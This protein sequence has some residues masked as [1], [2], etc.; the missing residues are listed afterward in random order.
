MVLTEHLS[1]V[2]ITVLSLTC[3]VSTLLLL[4][5]GLKYLQWKIGKSTVNCWFCNTDTVVPYRLR[6]RWVCGACK[7]YNGFNASGDYNDKVPAM[8]DESLNPTK[9]GAC[10]STD[11]SATIE[12]HVKL[13]SRCTRNQLLKV[14]QLAQFEPIIEENFELEAATFKVKLDKLYAL[15]RICH[16][17]TERHIRMQDTMIRGSMLSVQQRLSAKLS[18]LTA[19]RPYLKTTK[20]ALEQ[21]AKSLSDIPLIFLTFGVLVLSVIVSYYSICESLKEVLMLPFASY[22]HSFVGSSDPEKEMLHILLISGWICSMAVLSLQSHKQRSTIFACGVW[23]TYCFSAWISKHEFYEKYIPFLATLPF[24]KPAFVFKLISPFSSA[25]LLIFSSYLSFSSSLPKNKKASGFKHSFSEFQKSQKMKKTPSPKNALNTSMYSDC[26]MPSDDESPQAKRHHTQM[27]E[28]FKRP[29][30]VGLNG[31]L[32]ALNLK[33]DEDFSSSFTHFKHPASVHGGNTLPS[34]LHTPPPS[35]SSSLLSLASHTS[36]PGQQM[37][38]NFS[39][40]SVFAK[41][42]GEVPFQRYKTSTTVTGWTHRQQKPGWHSGQK[43]V[44]S[45]P[46]MSWQRSSQLLT[47]T[48]GPSRNNRFGNRPL[49]SPG[50]LQWKNAGQKKRSHN[51]QESNPKNEPST[52]D[53]QNS[54]EQKSDPDVSIHDSVSQVGDRG[55]PEISDEDDFSFCRTPR[56]LHQNSPTPMDLSSSSPKSTI[57]NLTSITMR[58]VHEVENS[59]FCRWLLAACLLINLI[60]VILLVLEVREMRGGE[61]WKKNSAK[62]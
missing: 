8:H 30:E 1:S 20:T 28:S 21:K 17:A 34:T 31:S 29:N 16:S 36:A 22:F 56:R 45:M 3:C 39:T 47:N 52:Q 44:A 51:W 10:R 43:S 37:Q 60:L 33:G 19:N 11:A 48:A 15:C 41:P 58:S 4:I 14:K 9:V 54:W 23:F 57:S 59:R 12:Q 18:S 5:A 40:N 50:K 32:N 42:T 49:I 7:Q 24:N 2:S 26:S 13:C 38:N 53:L 62:L 61:E 46:A 27:E 55:Q 35:R 25:L 6:N